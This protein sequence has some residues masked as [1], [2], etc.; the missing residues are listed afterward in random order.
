MAETDHLRAAALIDLRILEENFNTIKGK[1][2]PDVRIMGVV[3]ADAYGHGMVKIAEKLQS[4]GAGYLGV[5]TIDEGVELRSHGIKVPILVMSGLLPWEDLKPVLSNDLTLV[6]YDMATLKKIKE[7]SGHMNGALGIHLKIDTGMGRLGFDPKGLSPLI[8]EL[9]DSKNLEVAGIMSHFAS[10]ERRDKYGIGQVEAFKN[11]L[12]TFQKQSIGPGLVH[13]ANSGALA[14][15]PEAYFS[16]VRVGVNLYGSH[17]A[18]ELKEKIP[19]RPVMKLIS[20]IALIREFPPECSLSYG[21]TYTT[22]RATKV[23]FIP[24]GYSDGYPRALSNKG[25]VLVKDQRCPV[26]G[27]VCMDWVLV[28]I[29]GI[30][31]VSLG[32]EVVLMGISVS[33]GI[34]VDEIAELTGTIPYEI[35]CKISKRIPRIYAE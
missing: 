32:D 15:Y 18:W 14:N 30:D 3:K 26:V 12:E 13:M 35:L 7:A 8:K 24:V 9:G 33:E 17:A 16:M 5:A 20:R 31:G 10:S 22:K 11:V 34:T 23:A 28:D 25:F 4:I 29:N 19:L 2:P 1:L 6:V 21:R 27:R